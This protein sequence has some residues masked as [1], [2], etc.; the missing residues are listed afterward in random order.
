MRF[1]IGMMHFYNCSQHLIPLWLMLYMGTTRVSVLKYIFNKT[2][3]QLDWAP[4]PFEKVCFRTKACSCAVC[5]QFVQLRTTTQGGVTHLDHEGN[6]I[7]VGSITRPCTHVPDTRFSP[8]RAGS[9]HFRTRY[10]KARKVNFGGK[11]NEINP[12]RSWNIKQ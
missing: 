12:E 10:P 2:F 9:L 7:P 1:L 11:D 6:G 4:L 8:T 3:Q 5:V